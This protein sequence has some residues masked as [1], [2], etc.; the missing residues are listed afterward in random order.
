[1][2]E[3]L[4]SVESAPDLIQVTGGEPSIHPDIIEILKYLKSGPV[5]HLMINTN[6]I[7]ISQDEEFVKELKNI[8]KG[9]EVYLQFDSLD[10]DT[11]KKIR[12]GDMRS[13]RQKALEM[14]E[15]YNISTTLV[16]VIHK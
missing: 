10:G 4:L 1:M 6:G 13:T 12:N 9:F 3:T 8:G 2:H 14:L 16:C 11:L 7:R 5:R 15:K